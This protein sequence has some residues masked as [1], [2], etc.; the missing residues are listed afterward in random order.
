MPVKIFCCYAHEDE[1]LLKKLK[2]QL[3]PM[4]RKGLIEIWHDRDISAGTDWEREISKQLNSAQIIL[5]LISPDFIASDYCYGTEMKR[6]IER[7]NR[8]EAR[9]IPIILRPVHWEDILGNI[10]ALP[11]DAKPVMSSH[12]HSQDEALFDVA[13]GIRK[14][15]KDLRI[16]IREDPSPF[17]LHFIWIVSCGSSMAGD[18]IQSLNTAI[19]ESI[20]EM[21]HIAQS[22]PHVQFLIRAMKFSDGAQWHIPLATPVDQFQWVDLT[23]R[24]ASDMGKALMM[25][26]DELKMPPMSPRGLPPVLVLITDS[27]PTDDVPRGIQ[28]IMDQPWGKKSVRIGIGIGENADYAVLEKFIGNPEI[29]PLHAN[30]ADQLVHYI[31]WADETVENQ[32]VQ[33]QSDVW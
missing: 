3:T 20:P 2:I 29:K 19:R 8:K 6:A 12:W 23:S 28:A 17:P 10:Q 14:A 21:R 7:H 27:Y 4:Q 26:A 11:T 9:V 5:L 32:D 15:I 30:N 18:K 1:I 33:A 13:E 25:V 16:Y 31:K 22:H 24:G